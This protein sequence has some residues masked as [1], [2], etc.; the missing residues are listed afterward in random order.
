MLWVHFYFQPHVARKEANNEVIEPEEQIL[1]GAVGAI[2]IPICLFIFGWTSREE[3]VGFLLD[4]RSDR[5]A[6]P[7]LILIP[8]A[9]SPG[10]FLL[11][12][13]LFLLRDFI[14]R[15][16]PCS[17]IWV[18]HTRTTSPASL[19]AT[20]SSAAHLVERCRWLPDACYSLS[21]SDGHLVSWAS[22]VSPWSRSSLS[23]TGYVFLV[24][25]FCIVK[26]WIS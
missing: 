14:S 4:I 22:L 19:P 17:T 18:N 24:H 20:L 12:V 9:V 16:R 23:Y 26:H 13:P 1:P 21:A 8:Q 3:Y 15:S 2:C 7:E 10:S 6:Q 25:S 11:S 5:P